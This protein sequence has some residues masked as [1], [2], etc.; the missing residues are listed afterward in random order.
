M[1]MAQWG[2]AGAAAGA[3]GLAT[4]LEP[5]NLQQEV[6]TGS[7]NSLNFEDVDLLR[8]QAPDLTNKPYY[9]SEQSMNLSKLLLDDD[10][11][12]DNNLAQQNP[13]EGPSMV[14]AAT[15]LAVAGGIQAMRSVYNRL[16]GFQDDEMDDD[17]PGVQELFSQMP[18]GQSTSRTIPESSRW[19]QMQ[20]SMNQS[21]AHESTRG[22]TGGF[23]MNS[24]AYVTLEYL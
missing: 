17:T 6:M 13:A 10:E 3:F 16:R 15:P 12:F 20:S 1:K 5:Y 14:E 22:G 23:F 11:M 21:I 19:A 18:T 24:A 2:G 4:G 7:G 9:A 8:V